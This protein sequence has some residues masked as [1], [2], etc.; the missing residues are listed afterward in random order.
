MKKKIL[1]LDDSEERINR[2]KA[3]FVHDYISISR[4]ASEAIS[5]LEKNSFDI[6]FLDHDLGGK[7]Y[8]PSD[9]V[10]GYAVAEYVATKMNKNKLPSKI[11]IHSYNPSG[12][13]NMLAILHKNGIQAI[14]E[15]FNF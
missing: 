9:E 11:V 7:I 12:A 4:T 15:P 14:Y 1:F 10:S 2:F 3:K 13:K 6:L 8:C 5:L